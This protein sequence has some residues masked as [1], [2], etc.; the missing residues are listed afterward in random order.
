[1]SIVIRGMDLSHWYLTQRQ[2]DSG[3]HI[4]QDLSETGLVL[5]F[6][7]QGHAPQILVCFPPDINPSAIYRFIE[8]WEAE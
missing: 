5:T 1:M 3:F 7:A 2:I 8:I 4:D 6:T